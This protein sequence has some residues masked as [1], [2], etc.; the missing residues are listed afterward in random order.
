MCRFGCSVFVFVLADLIV[1][2]A[3]VDLVVAVGAVDLV[4]AVGAVDLIVAVVAIHVGTGYLCS[5]SCRSP[6]FFVV[7]DCFLL[8]DRGA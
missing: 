4:V 1:D 3:A 7:S 5:V 2:V 6:I 8:S